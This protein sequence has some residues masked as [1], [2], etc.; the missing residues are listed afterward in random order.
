MPPHSHG[1]PGPPAPQGSLGPPARRHG[2]RHR[3]LGHAPGGAGGAAGRGGG[4]ATVHGGA[5]AGIAGTVA[6]RD[7]MGCEA[8]LEEKEGGLEEGLRPKT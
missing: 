4:A 5:T 2:R 1:P 3:P 7:E 8:R 6:W